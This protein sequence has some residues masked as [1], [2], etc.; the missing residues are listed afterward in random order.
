LLF[1]SSNRENVS[2]ALFPLDQTIS[3]PLSLVIMAALITGLL[4]GRLL[5]IPK[6]I[7]SF[8][9]IRG[10]SRRNKVLQNEINGIKLKQASSS[11]KS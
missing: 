2:L 4:L 5:A 1:I 7:N 8:F 3:L 9:K 11:N 6:G 10:E